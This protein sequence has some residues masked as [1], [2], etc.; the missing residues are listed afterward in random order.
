M[1]RT[2]E[3]PFADPAKLKSKEPTERHHEVVRAARQA[4]Y[5]RGNYARSM[6]IMDRALARA[7]EQREWLARGAKM[8]ERHLLE[9]AEDAA[10]SMSVEEMTDMVERVGIL[11]HQM[12]I[13]EE[14]D[15]LTEEQRRI[16]HLLE[17]LP[18][19]SDWDAV[20]ILDAVADTVDVGHSD[21]VGRKLTDAEREIV[22]AVK[23][24]TLKKR[25]QR[26]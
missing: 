20:D 5:A 6:P 12:T 3:V 7:A 14:R 24:D 8:V 25:R 4:R 13:A 21:A 10:P 1:A 9:L 19:D 11:G 26:R 18:P 23:K 16:Q 22:F 17:S 15:W 2:P